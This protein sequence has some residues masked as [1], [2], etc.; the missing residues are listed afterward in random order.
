M[1][2]KLL[3]II[4]GVSFSSLLNGVFK[5]NVHT[6]NSEQDLANEIARISNIS[7]ERGYRIEAEGRLL[8]KAE[9]YEQLGH[10]TSL[11]KAI[12]EYAK[13]QSGR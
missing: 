10:S 13:K 8:T 11:F 1:L 7:L 4:V 3:N 12:L 5:L 9:A 2:W 6:V